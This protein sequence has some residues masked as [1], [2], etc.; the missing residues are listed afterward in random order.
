MLKPILACLA[1]LSLTQPVLAVSQTSPTTRHN[2]ID[3]S[4]QLAA[5]P[6]KPTATEKALHKAQQAVSQLETRLR[7]WADGTLDLNDSEVEAGRTHILPNSADLDRVRQLVSAAGQD[8]DSQLMGRVYQLRRDYARLGLPVSDWSSWNF[9][10]RT[11]SGDEATLLAR[12]EERF[13]QLSGLPIRE[14]EVNAG[15]VSDLIGQIR[16]LLAE[17]AFT[18]SENLSYYRQMYA[19]DLLKGYD[20][21][22]QQRRVS[23]IQNEL[24][25]L[26]SSLES[27]DTSDSMRIK[28]LQ[29]DAADILNA[30][31]VMESG[32]AKLPDMRLM[33]SSYDGPARELT[34]T[35][36][37]D[38]LRQISEDPVLFYHT[39]MHLA[40]SSSD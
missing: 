29:S 17:P 39:H 32:G 15:A 40:P 37:R 4:Y 23:G 20:S 19:E 18:Q 14:G 7:A 28:Q 9:D 30:I 25:V 6:T 5:K 34:L 38:V 33:V 36:L 21:L 16:D 8:S 27:L 2:Q 11:L 22:V 35:D 3:Q 24:G 10:G 12:V 1:C 31:S 13:R 26:W